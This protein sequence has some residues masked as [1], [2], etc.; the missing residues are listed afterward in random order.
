VIL[1]MAVKNSVTLISVPYPSQKSC[2]KESIMDPLDDFLTHK[3]NSS[4]KSQKPI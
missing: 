4:T 2:L 1:A 3:D